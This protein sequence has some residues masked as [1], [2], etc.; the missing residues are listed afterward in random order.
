MN[1]KNIQNSV[2][3]TQNH[4]LQ[5]LFS[6]DFSASENNVYFYANRYLS[7]FDGEMWGFTPLPDEGCYMAP[8][9]SSEWQLSSHSRAEGM[10][11]SS[12]AAGIII[13]A[14]V[15]NHRSWFFDRHDEEELCAHFCRRHRQLMACAATHPEAETI[16]LALV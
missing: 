7:G 16:F 11:V 8:L 9:V 15:L 5:N 13:T 1:L 2:A 10:T 4:F 12:D 6:D 14:L 3:Y